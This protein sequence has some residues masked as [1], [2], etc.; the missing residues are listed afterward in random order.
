M[1]HFYF[2]IL[3]ITTANEMLRFYEVSY[4]TENVNQLKVDIIG[5]RLFVKVQKL[6]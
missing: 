4:N 1:L 6:Y 3:W 2:N 5:Q